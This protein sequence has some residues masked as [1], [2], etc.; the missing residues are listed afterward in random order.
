MRMMQTLQRGLSVLDFVREAGEPVRTSDI[1]EKFDVDKANASRLLM[2]LHDSGWVRRT[3]DR[4]YVIGTKFHDDNGKAFEDLI[5]L[6]ETTHP[7]LESLVEITG[8]YAHM[9]ICVN[10]RV[11]YL[12]KV[13]SQQILRVDHPI[14]TLAPLH[15]T[16]LGKVFLAFGQRR[17]PNHLQAYTDR[18]LLDPLAIAENLEQARRDGFATDCEE[19]SPGVSCVAV[20]VWRAGGAVVAAVGLSGPSSRVTAARMNDLGRLLRE[21]CRNLV[22]KSSRR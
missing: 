19:F 1:A 20:P 7:L 18:T 8:E 14:G 16:A 21:R 4:R 5:E 2:T 17:L 15:C 3:S 22:V 12:D 6:R 11:W 10:D 13:S 9:A